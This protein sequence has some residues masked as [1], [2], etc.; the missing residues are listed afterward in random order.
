MAAESI[1]ALVVLD[2]SVH[3]HCR[4]FD[5]L[6]WPSIVGAREV[7]LVVPAQVLRELDKIK[8]QHRSRGVRERVRRVVSRLKDLL[9]PTADGVVR[10]KVTIEFHHQR[11]SSE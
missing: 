6:D 10:A 2:T 5:E 1:N 11:A 4:R 3:V 9:P 7:T 8:D